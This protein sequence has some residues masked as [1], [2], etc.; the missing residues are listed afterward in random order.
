[1]AIH[2]KG[3]SGC[4]VVLA[5]LIV[6]GLTAGHFLG[7]PVW[8]AVVPCALIILILAL[9]ALPIKK[10]ITPQQFADGLEPHLLGTD[11]TWGWDDITSV[12]LADE[13]LEQ[14][15]VQ[16]GKF[17]NLASEEL[18]EELRQLIAALRR[19]EIP[20]IGDN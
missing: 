13:R 11:G 17:D 20:E 12:R 8:I 19:G 16:L 7:S 3:S 4:L 14:I 18:R 6:V 1:M 15:R 10:K 5:V 2:L 9:A